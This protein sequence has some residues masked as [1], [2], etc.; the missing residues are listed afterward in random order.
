MVLKQFQDSGIVDKVKLKI[1]KR[2]FNPLK[3]PK[4]NNQEKN[5]TIASECVTD[6]D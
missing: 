5:K 6:L 3:I 4:E 2:I 1:L